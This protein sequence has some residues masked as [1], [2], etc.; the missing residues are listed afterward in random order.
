MFFMEYSHFALLFLALALALF[1]AEIFIPSGGMITVAAILCLAASVWCAWKAWWS[2]E[3]A[4][5][6]TYVA[7]VVILIPAALG[8]ALYVFPRTAWGRQILLEAPR[9][10]DVAPYAQEEERLAHLVGH[11]G[12]TLTL[13]NPG[14][15]VLLNGERM[16]CISEGILIDPQTEVEVIAVKGNR[17][18]VRVAE[19]P[20]G[21]PTDVFLA[22][23]S[24]GSES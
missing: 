21:P 4:Y 14:G 8:G 24:D 2:S 15:L 23:E 19:R 13:M 1:A 3:P 17:P 6:W 20:A 18:V 7:A 12:K 5:W 10:E 16:H 11:R 9:P 22:D